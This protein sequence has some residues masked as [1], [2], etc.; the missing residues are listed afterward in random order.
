LGGDFGPMSETAA[1]SVIES[2]LDS[3]INFFDT[4]DV[5]GGGRSEQL[6]GSNLQNASSNALI[7]TKYGRAAGT[8]P[9]GYSLAD[10][11]DS[12]RRAQD[13]LQRDHIDL[14]QL[15]CVPKPIVAKGAIF[16]WLRTIQQEGHIRW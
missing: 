9:D 15:H 4:A 5:Y 8:Y 14:L 1:H 13:R 7:A 16:D 6:L 12:V 2:A 11:R 3:Q 10:M